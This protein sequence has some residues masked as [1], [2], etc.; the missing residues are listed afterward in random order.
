MKRLRL[1]GLAAGVSVTVL[2]AGLLGLTA[3]AIRLDRSEARARWDAAF[4]ED[5]RLALWR[6]DTTAGAFVAREGSGEEG[7]GSDLP[8]SEKWVR[9]RFRVRLDSAAGFRK[10]SDREVAAVSA[11]IA[12]PAFW[13]TLPAPGQNTWEEP[14]SAPQAPSQVGIGNLGSVAALSSPTTQAQKSSI[15][16]VARRSSITK[17]YAANNAPD[18]SPSDVLGSAQAVWL[19]ANLV[20]A[21]RVRTRSGD[22]AQV[23]LLDW[24]VMSG[25]LM[26]QVSDLLPE[27]RL[28]PV[29]GSP[30]PD[31]RALVSLPARIVASPPPLPGESSPELVRLL[32]VVW[33]TSLFAAAAA[34]ALFF[35]A[36]AL[37]ERR[38]A[39]VSAVTHELRTPLTTFRLYSEMLADRMLPSEEKRQEYLQ[40]LKQEASRLSHLVENVLSYARVERTRGVTQGGPI[41]VGAAIESLRPRLGERARQGGMRLEVDVETKVPAWGEISAT[42]Q[43]HFNLVDNA[44]KYAA[45]AADKRILISARREGRWVA[46]RVRDFGP[47]LTPE[48]TRHLFAPFAKSAARAAL[49]APGVGLGLSLCRSLA[50]AQ[51]GS[52]RL[53]GVPGGGACFALRLRALPT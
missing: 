53:E 26:A 7:G 48:D 23:A 19:G 32:T 38:A 1:T 33:L 39:F 13:Q 52:L 34:L 10:S 21:R 5:V 29:R 47:G 12:Q 6:I 11:Q 42:E 40:T 2:L 49:T 24:P 14:A 41:E 16:Q 25:S 27:A 50:K 20:V 46:I 22:L 9:K 37:A 44:C 31:A 18:V 30:V 17:M 35:G 45:R 28:E 4:E 36:Q 8:G 51:K 15:E 3:A 43:V